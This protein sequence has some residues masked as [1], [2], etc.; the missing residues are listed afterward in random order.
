M[1]RRKRKRRNPRP[2]AQAQY[3]ALVARERAKQDRAAA[4]A[5]VRAELE[6]LRREIKKAKERKASALKAIREGCAIGRVQV[7]EEKKVLRIA[8]QAETRALLAGLLTAERNRCA[9]RKA[10][11][12]YAAGSLV[13]KR[14]ARL[15]EA[16]E[17]ARALRGRKREAEQG[18]KKALREL[19]EES[20][21]EVRGNLDP[22]MVPVFNA[23]QK[24][25]RGSEKRSRTEAFLEWAEAHPG[26][27][28]AIR[29]K[30]TEKELQKMMREEM[31][32]AKVVRRA[33]FA[34]AVP[35]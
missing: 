11:A 7:R 14:K 1:P 25:I 34:E 32:L 27:V 16:R 20:A 29:E 8:R 22:G 17:L 18:A 28:W 6:T 30:Q 15:R 3:R 33:G 21:D 4:R 13:E 9:V 24:T 10:A 19:H 26:E 23:V 2:S 5:K 35:F 31:R 12:V